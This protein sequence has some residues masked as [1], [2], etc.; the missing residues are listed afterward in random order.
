MSAAKPS[1]Q[2]AVIGAINPALTDN[3]TATTGWK[4]IVPGLYHAYRG[5]VLVGA[6][7][8]TADITLKYATDGSGT[9]ATALKTATQLSAT[10]DNKQVVIDLLASEIPAT[11][12]HLALQV[13]CG[14][15]SAGVYV[16]GV[17]EGH[18]PRYAKVTQAT[19]VAQVV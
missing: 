3:A 1:E 10:D 4:S 13:A 7:D 6:M 5:L 12:T 2:V 9:G 16:A 15:G 19:T 14:D 18:R 8:I 11:A 17:L